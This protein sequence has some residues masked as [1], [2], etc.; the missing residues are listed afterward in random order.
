MASDEALSKHTFNESVV[1]HKGD[2]DDV[3]QRY[4]DIIDILKI[5][6]V[7]RVTADMPFID[8]EICQILLQS[9]FETGADYTAA[10]DAAVGTNL[11]IINT[12]ALCEVKKHFPSSDYSEYMTWYFMNNQAH[13]KI[14]L[15]NLPKRLVRDYRLTLDY[16]EDL[17]LFN[18][19][20]EKLSE[21]INY[22]INDVFKLL[23]ENPELP[24]INGH[25]KLKYKVDQELINT[26]NK[27][28]KIS[29][30]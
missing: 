25:I 19:I 27:K 15:V 20:H 26:L 10:K 6:V 4:M 18:K 1:F 17:V 24:E 29:L 23:D 14:N 8:D 5:D 30:S 22:N 2:P 28:T 16:D 7:I 3:I 12:Q 13:F 21:N 11:E 9:H